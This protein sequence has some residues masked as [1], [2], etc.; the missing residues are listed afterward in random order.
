[1]SHGIV[2]HPSRSSYSDVDCQ[3]KSPADHLEAFQLTSSLSPSS[4]LTPSQMKELI[5]D[6]QSMPPDDSSDTGLSDYGTNNI[7]VPSANTVNTREACGTPGFL[8]IQGTM[9]FMSDAEGSSDDNYNPI[10]SGDAVFVTR[11]AEVAMPPTNDTLANAYVEITASGVQDRTIYSSGGRLPGFTAASFDAIKCVE[12]GELDLNTS[13]KR[14]KMTRDCTAS[15]YGDEQPNERFTW[16]SVTGSTPVVL[17][18]LRSLLQSNCSNE[19]KESSSYDTHPHTQDSYSFEGSNNPSCAPGGSNVTVSEQ[20]KFISNTNT[21]AHCMVGSLMSNSSL[22]SVDILESPRSCSQSP[23]LERRIRQDDVLIDG[24]IPNPTFDNDGV[25]CLAYDNEDTQTSVIRRYG[26]LHLG[27]TVGAESGP[28]LSSFTQK[29]SFSTDVSAKSFSEA[30][31]LPDGA[32]DNCPEQSNFHFGCNSSTNFDTTATERQAPGV[33]ESDFLSDLPLAN[34]GFSSTKN[35]FGPSLMPTSA[36]LM[37]VTAPNDLRMLSAPLSAPLSQSEPICQSESPMQT[38]IGNEEGSKF[39]PLTT[40]GSTATMGCKSNN[41]LAVSPTT[42]LAYGSNADLPLEVLPESATARERYMR[43]SVTANPVQKLHNNQLII[44]KR[45][46]PPPLYRPSTCDCRVRETGDCCNTY[47][48]PGSCG[49]KS[50]ASHIRGRGSDISVRPG[51]ATGLTQHGRGN[52]NH[53]WQSG[54]SGFCMTVP[55]ARRTNVSSHIRDRISGVSARGYWNAGGPPFVRH[56]TQTPVRANGVGSRPAALS[57]S[58]GRKRSAVRSAGLLTQ[59]VQ[60]ANTAFQRS[61]KD[62]PPNACRVHGSALPGSHVHRTLGTSASFPSLDSGTDQC[63]CASSTL[64]H[65]STTDS[66]ITT[67]RKLALHSGLT[68]DAAN[69]TNNGKYHAPAARVISYTTTPSLHQMFPEFSLRHGC[70]VRILEQ[71]ESQHRARYQTEGSRGAVKDRSGCGFPTIQLIGWDGRASLQVF[72]A[73]EVGRPRPHPFYQAYLVAG[74]LTKYCVQTIREGVNV[75]EM[76]FTSSNNWKL[77]LAICIHEI[78]FSIAVACSS[79]DLEQEWILDRL[80]VSKSAVSGKS[81]FSSLSLLFLLIRS[82]PPVPPWFS[83]PGSGCF[84]VDRL[85]RKKNSA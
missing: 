67:S 1:M 41:T 48:W 60:P 39:Q 52:L 38:V 31:F 72:V 3:V 24:S 54:C 15:Y 57:F 44:T 16:E 56:F 33:T 74:K 55:I 9:S 46:R 58:Q 47:S 32:R 2:T 37:D 62:I 63:S 73:T 14:P 20:T 40:A 70:R 29:D 7:S 66:Y 65:T 6:L 42:Y 50:I 28:L 83:T 26:N 77:S 43:R 13:S 64:V 18:T 53:S 51:L 30:S 80:L 35:L 21:Q 71:P 10:A 79:T 19:L 84:S 5:A 61:R 25:H 75:I 22:E 85:I 8:N 27:E 59:F 23:I 69:L 49:R 45:V 11:L 4:Q 34:E 82:P 17:P 68:H 12:L 78:F 76:P 81:A 36:P